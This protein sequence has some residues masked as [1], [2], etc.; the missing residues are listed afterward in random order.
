[1]LKFRFALIGA[2]TTRQV[3]L[4]RTRLSIEPAPARHAA[5]S[6]QASVQR[7]R[8]TAHRIFPFPRET[9]APPRGMQPVGPAP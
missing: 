2:L 3:L 1:M 7:G 8:R 6:P 4:G 5:D 9:V